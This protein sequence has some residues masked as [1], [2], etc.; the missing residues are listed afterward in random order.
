MSPELGGW[1]AHI[2][3]QTC[4]SCGTYSNIEAAH[5]QAFPS[6]KLRGQFA[7]RSHKDTRAYSCIPLC[8]SCHRGKDGIHDG[9]ETTW[10]EDN[11]PGGRA[12]V[13]GWVAKQI[14]EY[15]VE[16]AND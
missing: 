7:P 9:A 4:L 2:K 5:I 13:F 3:A 6:N 14:C 15:F 12:W 10:L 8:V 1:Y 11:I 16:R